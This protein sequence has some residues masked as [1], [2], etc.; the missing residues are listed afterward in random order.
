M[1]YED[2]KAKQLKKSVGVQNLDKSECESYYAS[3]QELMSEKERLNQETDKI[4]N[5]KFLKMVDRNNAIKSVRSLSKTIDDLISMEKE[6]I[7]GHY[8]SKLVEKARAAKE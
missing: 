7:D 4:R 3:M 5:N 8:N 6:K 1:S 2:K